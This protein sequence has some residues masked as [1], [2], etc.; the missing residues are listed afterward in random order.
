M[1]NQNLT[2]FENHLYH[3]ET[4]NENSFWLDMVIKIRSKE[5]CV[6]CGS[7]FVMTGRGLVCP[8]HPRSKPNNYFLDWFFNGERFKLYGFDSF[9]GV[10][11]RAATIDDEIKTGRFRVEHYKG[12]QARTKSKYAFEDRYDKWIKQKAKI[13]KP[14][15][16]KKLTQYKTGFVKVFGRQDVRMIG[17]DAILSYYEAISGGISN[18]TVYNL[19]G[20]LHSFFIDLF[21]REVISHLPK[22]PKVKYQRKAPKWLGSAEQAEILNAIPEHHRPIFQFLFL[23]GCRPSEARALKWQDINLKESVIE[24]KHS[25]SA[26]VLTT[27]KTGQSRVIPLTE[28]LRRLLQSKTRYLHCDFVFNIRGNHYGRDRIG[29]VWREACKKIGLEGIRPYDGTRHS[30]ASQLVNKGKSLEIIGKILGHSNTQT[31]KKYSR[32]SIDAMRDA[33]EK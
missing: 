32:V 8:K 5:N 2:D 17:T 33:M 20:A 16:V 11:K 31:T 14:G 23:T 10:V 7:L 28:D 27:T 1:K 26:G 9:N 30:F 12:S 6:K 19:I 3:A 21:D 18:K 24:I 22:F 13:R 29:K 4:E 25:F 15:Y